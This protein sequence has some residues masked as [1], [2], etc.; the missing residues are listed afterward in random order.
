MEEKKFSP[1]ELEKIN[2]CYDQAENFEKE[3]LEQVVKK[4]KVTY[5]KGAQLPLDIFDKVKLTASMLKDYCT[6]KY[7]A[8]PWKTIASLGFG[9]AYLI[10]PLDVIPDF[11][12]IAGL[13]DDALLLS[14]FFIGFSRDLE[15]YRIWKE[16]Q[17]LDVTPK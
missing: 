12:P 11:I 5:N 6:G 9:I 10:S 1:D 8:V 16:S 15:D 7:K 4:E 17:P 3:D 14:M 2:A 13:S